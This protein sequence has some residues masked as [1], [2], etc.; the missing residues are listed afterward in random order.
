MKGFK[1]LL[2]LVR[3]WHH[4]FGYGIQSPSVYYY[5]KYV[6]NEQSPYYAYDELSQSSVLPHDQ[7][8]KLYR[9]YLRLANFHQPHVWLDLCPENDSVSKYIHAG[10]R[11]TSYYSVDQVDS[12]SQV[13]I[14]RVLSVNVSYEK[15]L[16]IMAPHSLLI[17]NN[18]RNDRQL[19]SLWNEI[20][21]DQRIGVTIDMYTM[22]IAFFD[23]RP[24]QNNTIYLR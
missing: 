24:K 11:H 21:A 19:L 9:L 4:S 3:R 22:G 17:V 8:I 15:L 18:I 1:D 16:Q 10:C 6:L 20:V 2:S 13:D 23:S 5:I 7:S 12:L 14:A